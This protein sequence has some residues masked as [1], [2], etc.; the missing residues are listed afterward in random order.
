VILV[1][2]SA[3]IDFFRATGSNVGERLKSL[4]RTG[5]DLATTDPIALELLVGALG[6]EGR[7]R[8]RSALAACRSLSVRSPYDWEDAVGVHLACRRGGETPR[9]ML[10]CLIAAVAIRH[11]VPILAADRDFEM[12]ARHLPLRI[13]EQPRP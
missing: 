6:P 10:D 5:E 13:A 3:W 7:R 1:D 12:I 4:V 9:G 11:D 8:V 2:S